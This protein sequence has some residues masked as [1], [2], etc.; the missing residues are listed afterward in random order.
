LTTKFARLL[1]PIVLIFSFGATLAQAQNTATVAGSI[2]TIFN[3]ADTSSQVCFTL[4]D[5]RADNS[6]SYQ[7]PVNP[8]VVGVGLVNNF[9]TQCV[10]ATAGSYSYLPFGNDKITTQNGKATVW[11]VTLKSKHGGEATLGTYRFLAGNT[12]DLASA[13]PINVVPAVTAPTGDSTYARLDGGNLPFLG[14]ISFNFL[15][16]QI[17]G[18]KFTETTAPTCLAGFDFVWADSTAHRMKECDNGGAAVQNVRSGVDINASDQVTVTHLAA[19]LP[20]LQGGTGVTVAQ[21]T[22]PKNQLAAGTTTTSN[23]LSYDANGNAIDSTK[24]VPSGAVVGTTDTQNLS[25]KTLASPAFTGSETGMSIASPTITGAIT[26]GSGFA[27]GSAT[28][29]VNG[30]GSLAACN[31]GITWGA[32]LSSSTYTALCEIDSPNQPAHI[33]NTSSKTT[34]TMNVS[35]VNDSANAVTS[36]TVRCIAIP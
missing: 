28:T 17:V 9:T 3:V 20:V 26:S 34:T 27:K 16:S 35:V 10:D 18:E 1:P 12:Y 29:C 7:T 11:A 4:R 8:H 32:T 33:G 23:L 21:G 13:T 22:G 31:L 5:T 15:T 36:G 19:A 14:P 30:A 2:K 25:A 6:G 24:A